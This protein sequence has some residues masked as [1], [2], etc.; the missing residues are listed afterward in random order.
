MITYILHSALCLTVLMVFYQL[1]LAKQKVNHVKRFYLLGS[2]LLSG[3][4]PWINF[5]IPINVAD[6]PFT[7]Y[8]FNTTVQELNVI[9]E[10]DGS[11]VIFP[12]VIWL[13][14]IS[15][16]VIFG[17]R[18][19]RN[20]Y[21]IQKKIQ[22]SLKIKKS[23][24][25]FILSE[26]EEI[27]HTFLSFIFI[28]KEAYLNK[29]IPSEIFLHE[30]AHVRQ[31]HTLDILFVELLQ[32]IF[33]FNPLLYWVKREMKLNH[34]YLADEMVIEQSI[35]PIKYINLL[36][37]YPGTCSKNG[38]V[39]PFNFVPTKKR[40]LMMSE[41]FSRG[42]FALRIS[43]LVPLLLI[44]IINFS[45]SFA[46]IP[47][48]SEE[49][50]SMNGSIPDKIIVLRVN[51]KSIIVN[52][53]SNDLKDFADVMNEATSNWDDDDYSLHRLDIQINEDVSDEYIDRI[54]KK[55][56]ETD[57]A[58]KSSISPANILHSPPIPIKLDDF[59]NEIS[60]IYLD[61]KIISVEE[62]NQLID[63][64]RDNLEISVRE[65]GDKPTVVNL[66]FIK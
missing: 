21:K 16:V 41:V 13:I 48:V 18:F 23:T 8:S 4:I 3:L 65:N 5:T 30:E 43:L 27:P 6:S 19:V 60:I 59:I 7:V 29:T 38:I 45:D 44:S 57:L 15:G 35:D 1:A 36:I 9:S 2:L 17:F 61:E 49:I 55:F 32:I 54:N 34:E 58:E 26:G 39:S 31:K 52:G 33:W 46:I 50:R 51:D 47:I 22:N 25:A 63:N 42:K 14:Y 64:H 20:L 66:S 53:K 12:F 10:I 56:R 40:I 37:S 28:S 11:M 62:A 24:Y